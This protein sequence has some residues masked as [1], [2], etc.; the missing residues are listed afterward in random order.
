LIRLRCIG[1]ALASCV[2]S[3]TIA[4]ASSAF[5][6]ELKT[7]SDEPVMFNITAQ[8]LADALVAYGAATGLEVYYDGTIA[9]GR[10]SAPVEGSF[11]PTYGLEILLQGTGYWPQAT[12]T[13]SFTLVSVEQA[14]LP[15]RVNQSQ[16]SRHEAYFAALQAGIARALC[17][18]DGDFEKQIVFSF[19]V[20]GTGAIYQTKILGSGNYAA[21]ADRINTVNIG[22]S[23]PTDVAQP[24][25]MAVYP[26]TS[27]DAPG[28]SPSANREAGR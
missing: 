21:I 26:S 23:P 12:G 6:D 5:P 1:W 11:T 8:P 24:V 9:L 15:A 17:G 27:K 16:L 7:S 19:R 14:V 4:A 25:T 13:D 22:R 2:A 20:A 18:I 3:F 10:R 28:C